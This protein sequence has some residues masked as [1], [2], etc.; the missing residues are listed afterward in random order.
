MPSALYITW[1]KGPDESKVDFA[2]VRYLLYP[3]TM[4]TSISFT[5]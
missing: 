3:K 2:I 4:E 1:W 5:Q